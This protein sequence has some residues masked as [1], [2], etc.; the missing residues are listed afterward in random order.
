LEF[1]WPALLLNL[2]VLLL[3]PPL[4]PG[5]IN[6]VKSWVGG[7]SGPPLFQLY[8]DL[9]KLWRKGSVYS[10]SSTV[11]LRWAPLATLAALLGAGL[12]FP[13]AGIAAFRFEG[14]LIL[15]V[16]LLALSRLATILAALDVGSS[17]ESM[18]AS[19]EAVYSAFAEL[20]FVTGLIALGVFRHTFSMGH[21]F[22][23]ASGINPFH[24][25]LVL[26]FF[27]FFFVL[28]S[29]NS[30][31]PVD[32]PNTH[33]EL[34]MIHEVMI[35]DYSGPELGFVLYGAAMKLMLHSLLLA[36]VLWPV[37]S[38]GLFA[39]L[40][41][42]VIKAVAVAILIGLV[43]SLVARLRLMVVPQFLVANFMITVL[44]FLVTFFGKGF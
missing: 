9:A 29:E 39:S 30:R 5:V 28:L 17:F 43:E 40:V 44:A 35:L 14:D 24:P 37:V 34:T 25:G 20:P 12:L 6:R 7:R 36:S 2:L 19:R 33:L 10:L 27:S 42:T 13:W 3:L 16:Y 32:D 18:G 26:L 31:M 21:L 38:V 11:I 41:F 4:L 22:H 1:S 23:S 8:F 15:F